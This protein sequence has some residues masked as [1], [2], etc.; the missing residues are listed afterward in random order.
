VS[1]WDA[2]Q[3]QALFD[4]LK[5]AVQQT[6][7]F[8]AVDMHEPVSPPG[9]R[10]YCSII[11]AGLKPVTSS[12]LNVTS[13]QVTFDMRIWSKAQQR[14]LD[15]I[16]PEIVAAAATVI[17]VLSGELTLGETVRDIDLL[18]MSGTPGW[19]EFNGEQFRVMSIS[20]PI[21]INDLFEQVA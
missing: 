19:V 13:G 1:N 3:V 16:D 10:L 8:Q 17:G 18:S 21:V 6:A 7:L 5:S 4:A 11:F 12:G 14:P 2:A 20:I 9:V 15:K